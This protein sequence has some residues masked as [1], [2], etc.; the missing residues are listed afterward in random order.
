MSTTTTW[1]ISELERHTA[2]GIVYTAHYRVDATDG[3]YRSGAYG[4]IG[5]EAPAEGDDVVAYADL[6]PELVITWV[7]EALGT[8][9]VEQVEAALASQIAEQAAPTTAKGTPW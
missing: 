9:Q 8:E 3:T 5:L 7:K 2:D 4:S 6:T 1:S